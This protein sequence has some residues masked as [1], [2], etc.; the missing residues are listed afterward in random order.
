M[1]VVLTMDLQARAYVLNMTKQ[2]GES[3]CVSCEQPGEI[4]KKVKDNCHV[5]LY[6][7][8][9]VPTKRTNESIL[10]GGSCRNINM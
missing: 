8:S 7:E 5:Y 3:G 4:V 1:L 10:K 9:K 2:N 6:Y